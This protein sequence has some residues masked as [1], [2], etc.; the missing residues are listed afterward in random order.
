MINLEA[1]SLS[2]AEL[3]G[4]TIAKIDLRTAQGLT[5]I[6]HSGP[7]NIELFSIQLP[8]DGSAL[9]FLRGCGVPD[10]WIDFW[11]ITMTN[12]IQYH[13]CFISYSSK[14]ELLAKRLHADLQASGVRC[15]FAPE[16]LKIGDRIRS[17]IDE[18]IQLQDKL[19]LLLSKSALE[20]EWI[21]TEVEVAL[22]KE[23]RQGRDVLFPVRLDESIMNAE[24]AWAK[25]LR[26]KRH[27][28]D[29]T[30]WETNAQVYQSTFERLLSDLKQY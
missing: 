20:S 19:L 11:R 5:T 27:I 25:H 21:E 7:S 13:S 18:A 30:K 14:D 24:Q 9:Q 15:W 17:R 12:P 1:Y 6:R 29:L 4:T 10:E 28:G 8:Q 23:K 22:E 3:G 2:E 16:D 26:L